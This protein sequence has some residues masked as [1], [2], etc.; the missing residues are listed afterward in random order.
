MQAMLIAAGL[1]WR[2]NPSAHKR[3]VLLATLYISDAG[4]AR[5][6]GPPATAPL[7][8]TVWGLM[9]VLYLGNDSLVLGLGAYDWITRRCLHPANV[10]VVAWTVLL[11]LTGASL[12]LSSAW[13]PLA[14]KLIGH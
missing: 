8:A 14:L 1:L 5:W 9:A 13:K 3:L 6:L 12:Y 7:P 11:Q 4:F 10:A 2:R